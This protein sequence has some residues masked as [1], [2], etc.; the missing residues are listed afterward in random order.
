MGGCNFGS[1]VLVNVTKSWSESSCIL[2]E[3]VSKVVRIPLSGTNI[4][5][6]IPD[7]VEAMNTL[8]Q[9]RRNHSENCILA[10]VS[11]WTRKNEI[12]FANERSGRAIFTT[13]VCFRVITNDW[14][15]ELLRSLSSCCLWWAH[16]EHLSPQIQLRVISIKF[17]DLSLYSTLIP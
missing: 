11:W 16:L 3:K 8:I 17:D 5:S 12:Y 9:K 13:R 4:Y 6:S 15:R 7:T 2:T 10:K 14:V 1:I